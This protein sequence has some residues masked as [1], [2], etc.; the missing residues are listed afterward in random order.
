MTV[1]DERRPTRRDFH[2]LEAAHEE[3]QGRYAALRRQIDLIQQSGLA[4]G[5]GVLS[6]RQAQ[7]A[8][9]ENKK[10]RRLNEVLLARNEILARRLREALAR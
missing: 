8:L 7:Q 5:P 3:L 9:D 4:K 2:T 10:M 1:V 6:R